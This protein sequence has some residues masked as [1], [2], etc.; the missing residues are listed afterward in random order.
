MSPS[1]NVTCP[2]RGQL[3]QFLLGHLT[4]SELEAVER[5]LSACDACVGTLHGLNAVDTLVE[6]ARSAREEPP[7]TEMVEGLIDRVRKLSLGLARR[8]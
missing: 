6:I 2:Q 7:E 3:V 8:A 5:H 4:G 1:D